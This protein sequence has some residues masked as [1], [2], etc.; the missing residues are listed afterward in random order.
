MPQSKFIIRF[1][2]LLSL[3]GFA[4]PVLG[5]TVDF[6]TEVAPVL[7]AKCLSCHNPN[8]LKGDFS[9]ATRADIIGAGEDI[10]IPGNAEESMLHWITLAFGPDEAA[11]MPEK[12]EPLTEAEAAK[13]ETW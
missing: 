11:E 5:Q 4:V 8:I 9:M 1:V 2:Y 3:W 13:L 10:L 12:G 6:E 7:E